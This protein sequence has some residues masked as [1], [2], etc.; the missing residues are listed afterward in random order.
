M[1]LLF[2]GL[3]AVIVSAGTFIYHHLSGRSSIFLIPEHYTGNIYVVFDQ[4][5]GQK[6]EY[7]AGRRLYRISESGILFTRFPVESGAGAP[8]F[9][10]MT[11]EG[12]RKEITK[13]S[14][15]NFYLPFA[16]NE[17]NKN[18]AVNEVS[19][20]DDGFAWTLITA[21]IAC[22]YR[23]AFIG[24]YKQLIGKDHY[25]LNGTSL[26]SLLGSSLPDLR[27]EKK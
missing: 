14:S 27:E 22:E 6:E 24:T 2:F 15:G 19:V 17:R 7:D 13:V 21:K 16:Q 9:Y 25:R 1:K 4:R 20:F 8:E 5:E 11:P 18:L 12:A 3:C 10:F 23:H 26:D